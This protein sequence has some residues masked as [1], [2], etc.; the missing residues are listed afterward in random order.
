M[1]LIKC[2]ECGKEISD[3]AKNCIN[4]G[5]V[6]KEDTNVAP[7]QT[8]INVEA[9]K[10]TKSSSK[11]LVSGITLFL[12]ALTI[13]AY[14]HISGIGIG[15]TIENDFYKSLISV[16]KIAA[17]VSFILFLTLLAIPKIRKTAVVIPYLIVNLTSVFYIIEYCMF[18]GCVY[19][20]TLIPQM[21]S[22][23]VSYVLIFIS[24]F[25]KD[26]KQ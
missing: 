6:L 8:V 1:A 13:S 5:Y 22:L 4:C 12:I 14:S 3:T 10:R 20:I 23:L 11:F 2:P 18:D 19:I 16:S 9:P 21:L 24:L 7:Q 17:V 26:E 15:F 25:I